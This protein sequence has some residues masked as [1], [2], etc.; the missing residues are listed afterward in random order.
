M[1]SHFYL[2]KGKLET[3]EDS[4][5]SIA[6][7]GLKYLP[8]ELFWSI[9]R[10][11]LITGN[12]PIVTAISEIH[13]WQRWNAAGTTNINFVE[14]DIYIRTD[15]FDVIIEAKRWDKNQQSQNQKN[16]QIK[17]YHNEFQDSKKLLFYIELGG[18]YNNSPVSNYLFENI[19]VITCKTNW[20]QLLTSIITHYQNLDRLNLKLFNPQKRILED[21]IKGFELHQFYTIKWLFDLKNQKIDSHSFNFL[22]FTANYNCKRERLLSPL[23]NLSSISITNTT[24]NNLFEYA[25]PT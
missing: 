25:K 18:L 7:D 15:N 23:K 11:S 16:N 13:F 10:D 22:K 5:V 1:I 4:L 21:I 20:T 6:F 14:P 3:K 8:D 12:L 2:R 17:A 19:E 24:T 9:L